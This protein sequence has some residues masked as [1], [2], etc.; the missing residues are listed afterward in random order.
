MVESKPPTFSNESLA[1]P[2]ATFVLDVTSGNELFA[3]PEALASLLENE[4][5]SDG[6]WSK[7]APP[8]CLWI[9]AS[10]KAIRCSVNFNGERVNKV[11]FDQDELSDVHYVTRHGELNSMATSSHRRLQ[12]HCR[13]HDLGECHLLHCPAARVHH[14]HGPVLWRHHTPRGHAVV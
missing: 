13:A 7:E 11:E 9:A 12:G 14:A 10:K 2:L 6:K 5:T 4:P 8:H 3:S 1:N